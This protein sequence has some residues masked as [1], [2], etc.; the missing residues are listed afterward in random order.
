LQEAII[1]TNECHYGQFLKEVSQH[2]Q[3]LNSVDLKVEHPGSTL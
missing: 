3:A 2:R 1:H